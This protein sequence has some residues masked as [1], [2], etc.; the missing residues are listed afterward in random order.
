MA[1]LYK[2]VNGKR[3]KLKA[4]EKTVR[5][6]EESAFEATRKDTAIE[7]AELLY[8][9][10]SEKRYIEVDGVTYDLKRALNFDFQRRNSTKIRMK[11][12]GGKTQMRTK[13]KT[14]VIEAARISYL[15]SVADAFDADMDAIET[16][17][18]SL[19]N[20]RGL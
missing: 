16:G 14:D 20:L 18:Y 17:D 19:S 2:I 13:A 12:K 1:D 5:E 9:E 6:A 3:V 4:A 10:L 15:N 8:D 11:V 7:Q